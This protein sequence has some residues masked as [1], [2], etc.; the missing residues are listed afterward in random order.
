VKTVWCQ[1]ADITA[2]ECY[3]EAVDMEI[4]YPSEPSK[5]FRVCYVA[6]LLGNKDAA[7]HVAMAFNI[8]H[9]VKQSKRLSQMWYKIFLSAHVRKLKFTPVMGEEDESSR[10]TIND[11][12]K[13]N[14]MIINKFSFGAIVV[15]AIVGMMSLLTGCDPEKIG[16]GGHLQPYNSF[17]GQYK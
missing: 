16:G 13:G 5:A 15:V 7:F 10:K 3:N 17:N 11:K 4:S 2:V 6:A 14:G 12:K 1:I 9:G 8:G